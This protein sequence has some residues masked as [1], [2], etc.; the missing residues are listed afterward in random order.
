MNQGTKKEKE[1]L[2]QYAVRLPESL[3]ARVRHAFIDDGIN[4]R[5]FVIKS[6]EEYLAARKS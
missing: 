3:Y 5:Q 4:M 1:K 2:V 6:I